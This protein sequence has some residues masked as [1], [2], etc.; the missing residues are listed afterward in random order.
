MYVYIICILCIPT[1]QRPGLPLDDPATPP[2]LALP[3]PSVAGHPPGSPWPLPAE[4]S[5]DKSE[6]YK[7]IK[8]ILLSF[9]E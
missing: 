7:K 8:G 3:G 5:V 6:E 4:E 2:A 1:A 9:L